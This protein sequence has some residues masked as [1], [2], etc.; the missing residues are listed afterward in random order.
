MTL[1][2]R[3]GLTLRLFF[4]A[5]RCHGL[6]WGNGTRG[7][8]QESLIEVFK[9]DRGLFRAGLGNGCYDGICGRFIADDGLAAF[10]MLLVLHRRLVPCVFFGDFINHALIM[11]GVLQIAFRQNAVASRSGV[12]CE[13]CI[14]FVDLI[15]VAANAHF[16]P[17][18]V[19]GLRSTVDAAVSTALMLVATLMV[20]AAT[21]LMMGILTA[22]IIAAATTETAIV[23]IVSHKTFFCFD[24]YRP[25]PF[26]GPLLSSGLSGLKYFNISQ[27][28]L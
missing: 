15:G 28:K 25:T 23:L 3:A 11:L 20:I 26:S 7:R 18:A 19:E 12:F 27:T 16:G 5:F 6:L 21:A 8:A 14:F 2:R 10:V 13:S 9:A 24:L 17:V 22:A 4:P 1:A